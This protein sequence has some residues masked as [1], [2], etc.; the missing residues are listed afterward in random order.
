MVMSAERYFFITAAESVLAL[1]WITK[2]GCL[3]AEMKTRMVTYLGG[4]FFRVKAHMCSASK[5]RGVTDF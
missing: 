4:R 5:T 2:R 3:H 1:R